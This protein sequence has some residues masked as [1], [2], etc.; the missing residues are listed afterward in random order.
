M[1]DVLVLYYS[2]TG[3]VQQMAQAVARG[4]ERVAGSFYGIPETELKRLMEE[5]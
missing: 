2:H 5:A 1:N 4:I 3:A